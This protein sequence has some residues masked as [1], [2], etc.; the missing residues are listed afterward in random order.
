M[1]NYVPS[2]SKEDLLKL[3]ENLKRRIKETKDEAK[4]LSGKDY[5]IATISLPSDEAELED[6]EERLKK[7]V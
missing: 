7:L 4:G 1:A 5:A 6:V 3:R 2:M